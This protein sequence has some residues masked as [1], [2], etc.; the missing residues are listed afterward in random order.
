M[1]ARDSQ[2]EAW[3]IGSGPRVGDLIVTANSNTDQKGLFYAWG[4]GVVAGKKL[5]AMDLVDVNPTVLRGL[6]RVQAEY[7]ADG[8]IVHELLKRPLQGVAAHAKP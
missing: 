7:T 3:R 5:P 6:I 2:P 1:T 8:K 4:R